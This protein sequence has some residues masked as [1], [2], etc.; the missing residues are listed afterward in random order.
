MV[1]EDDALVAQA[2]VNFLE[3]MGGDVKCFHSA[4]DALHHDAN[5]EY[6]DYYVVDY[7]LGG[8]VNGIQFL[9]LLRQKLGKPPYTSSWKYLLC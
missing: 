7:M 5:I 2:M 3:G 9:N 6:A 8:T 4:E 1:V